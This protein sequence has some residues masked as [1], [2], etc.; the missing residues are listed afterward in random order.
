MGYDAAHDRTRAIRQD[1]L[2]RLHASTTDRQCTLEFNQILNGHRFILS[3]Q[4]M[5][6]GRQEKELVD[7]QVRGFY[8]PDGRDLPSKLGKLR[9]CM[10][11]VEDDHATEAGQL[12][13]WTM[14]ISN[15]LVDLNVTPIQ[16][17]PLQPRLV[18]DVKAPVCETDT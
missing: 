7:D 11:Q 17:I 10:A 2:A 4:E 16:G 9:Q 6:H 12:S 15:A 3:V 14:D 1:Y 8:P 5:E 13:R 18:K